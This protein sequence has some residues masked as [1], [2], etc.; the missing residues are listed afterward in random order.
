MSSTLRRF[1]ELQRK[2]RAQVPSRKLSAQQKHHLLW[3]SSLQ[4]VAE[5][6]IA[7][8]VMGANIDRGLID[9]LQAEIRARLVSAGAHTPRSQKEKST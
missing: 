9:R 8:M 2:F 1:D 7:A 3:A 6:S 4:Q 5:Q